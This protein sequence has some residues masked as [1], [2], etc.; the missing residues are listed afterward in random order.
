MHISELKRGDRVLIDFESFNEYKEL[1]PHLNRVLKGWQ[2]DRD[3][4]EMGGKKPFINIHRDCITREDVF[5]SR[6]GNSVHLYNGDEE[7]YII[8]KASELLKPKS[9]IVDTYEI[10]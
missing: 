3:Y 8:Y 9:A 10:F 4:I 2:P 1:V 7:P 6:E 5:H